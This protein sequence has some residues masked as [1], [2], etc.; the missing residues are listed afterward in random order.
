LAI[1]AS[2]SGGLVTS[3][4]TT[5]K[6]YHAG[7]AARGGVAAARLAAA[8]ITA[9]HQTFEHAQ[10][11]LT[12]FS[13][14][15]PDR[16]PSGRLGHDWYILRQGLCIKLYPTC[17][18]MHRSFEAAR[19]LLAGRGVGAD[20]IAEVTVTM[21]RG[22]TDVLFNHR[23]QSAN[24]ARFS[25]EFAIAAAA[26]LGHMGIAELSDAVVRR[27]DLQAFYPKVRIATI[28]ERD[29]REPA[30]APY[31]RVRIRLMDGTLLDS[32]EVSRIHGHAWDPVGADEHW[33]K[34]AEC[35]A[36]THS[37]AAAR[38]LFDL[39]QQIDS[40]PSAR[41]LPGAAGVFAAA[42]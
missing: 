39:L 16:A 41:L 20:D 28:E 35:T 36:R 18:F 8:G 19:A 40:L 7:H 42:A 31:T 21:G 4:G 25:E 10:G 3:L 22:E 17:Y 32:G 1:A 29:P 23:P 5:T 15:T 34:F 37:P 6:A 33:A 11:F 38:R 26:I 27:A 13:P 9:G 24:E 14:G 2:H 30:M 12:A